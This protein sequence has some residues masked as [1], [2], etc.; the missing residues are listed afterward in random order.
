M[1]KIT[2]GG[3]DI[4]C[5]MKVVITGVIVRALFMGLSVINWLEYIRELR[6]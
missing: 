5:R 3:L 1:E 4:A 6:V 2:I